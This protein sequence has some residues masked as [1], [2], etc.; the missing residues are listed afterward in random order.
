[1]SAGM[2]GRVET[3]A[4]VAHMSRAAEETLPWLA[5]L[6]G[7]SACNGP[8]PHPCSQIPPP[9]SQ[10]SNGRGVLC[11]VRHVPE[12]TM[13]QNIDCPTVRSS[14]PSSLYGNQPLSSDETR[15]SGDMQQVWLAPTLEI[16]DG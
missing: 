9:W 16:A 4:S 1:M 3:G 15:V 14:E 10:M 12:P 5:S 11:T 8:D 2:V 7:C 6:A 13:P